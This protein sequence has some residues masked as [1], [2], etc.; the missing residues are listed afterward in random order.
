MSDDD[1]TPSQISAVNLQRAQRYID[2]GQDN[3]LPILKY[4]RRVIS[5]NFPIE[6]D[7]GS[8]D[9]YRGYRVLH[10][11]TL[12][13]GKGGIRFH[14]EV[15]LDEVSALAM[16]MTWKCALLEIPFGGAKGGVVCDPKSLSQG[17]LR[18]I[19]RRFISELGDD[20]GPYT[21]IPSPDL[22]TDEQTMAWVYD[23]YDVMH[24][25]NN[26]RAVVTGKPLLLGG[27]PGR[28]EATARGCVSVTEYFIHRGLIPA[29]SELRGS[30]VAIQGFGNVGEVAAQLFSECG[31]II[32][33]LS[34]SQ[35]GIADGEGIDLAEAR[36]FKKTT[37]TLVGLAHTE[38]ITNSDL[39]EIDCD[40]LIPA[41]L[42]RQITA[43]NAG[44]IKAKVIV[45]AANGPVTP[46]ADRILAERGI[47]LLPDILANAG[48]VTVSYF[49]WLQNLDNET[50]QLDEVN[51]RLHQRMRASAE[52][53]I[54][55]WQ[56][57]QCDLSGNEDAEYPL[58]LRTAAL[59][60]A[61]DRLAQITAQ[62]GIWP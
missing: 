5:V 15:D 32:V 50:W 56:Y 2:S 30:R 4:P 51:S 59:T 6:M 29:L 21:D 61:V 35:G 19:T 31:A 41:A 38:T 13:P 58:D 26:N 47:W 12:G 9:V 34:D 1:I 55:R 3:L 20:L 43:D 16:L 22:Y 11:R 8:V 23:T 57:L 14:P 37:G 49:E 18:R 27:S 54:A 25:G 53:T 39:L 17:E 40:V 45:E 60:L 7:D 48:G 24:Q 33:A 44:N 42:G 62:R 52:A 36:A 46:A 10:N 28:R